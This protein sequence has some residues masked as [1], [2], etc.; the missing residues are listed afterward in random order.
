[1]TNPLAVN[2]DLKLIETTRID[3]ILYINNTP[4]SIC[5][6]CAACI[7]PAGTIIVS[8]VPPGGSIVLK[9]YDLMGLFIGITYGGSAVWV[10]HT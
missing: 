4:L 6:A 3:D 8:N 1:L 9:V 7:L 5:P 2:A 10:A